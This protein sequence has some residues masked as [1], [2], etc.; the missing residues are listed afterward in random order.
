MI[1][2]KNKSVQILERLTMA[3]NSF[4][5]PLPQL[6]AVPSQLIIK[7]LEVIKKRVKGKEKRFS[8]MTIS[9][10]IPV[11]EGA[12]GSLV[13]AKDANAADSGSVTI[14]ITIELPMVKDA[15]IT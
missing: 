11:E 14:D 5:I 2:D 3:V 13:A 8:K 7:D 1:Q 10:V 15:S 6:P 4:V 12:D 9:F